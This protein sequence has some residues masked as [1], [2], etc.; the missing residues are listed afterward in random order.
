MLKPVQITIV[1][2]PKPECWDRVGPSL[3]RAPTDWREREPGLSGLWGLTVSWLGWT[4]K[5][6]RDSSSE[7]SST[8]TWRAQVL[9]WAAGMYCSSSFSDFRLQGDHLLLQA[10]ILQLPV[11]NLHL[12]SLYLIKSSSTFLL[13]A[14][15]MRSPLLQ[16]G[17]TTVVEPDIWEVFLSHHHQYLSVT[18]SHNNPRNSTISSLLYY[19]VSTPTNQQALLDL[20]DL[21]TIIARQNEIAWPRSP[22]RRRATRWSWC[23]PWTGWTSSVCCPARHSL[24]ERSSSNLKYIFIRAC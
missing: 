13:F 1:T 22:R 23:P 2:R 9:L 3:L 4:W 21:V 19:R 6:T 17:V 14:L 15:P 24:E 8:F 20:L 11:V 16:S 18:S 7:A 10:P 5:N 12:E